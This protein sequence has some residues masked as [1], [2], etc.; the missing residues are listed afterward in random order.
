MPKC[1]RCPVDVPCIGERPAYAWACRIANASDAENR[2][3]VEESARQRG[4]GPPGRPTGP[5]A[6]GPHVEST[7]QGAVAEFLA[8]QDCVHRR[9]EPACGC[10]A[11]SRC[12]K[13]SKDVGV[14]ECI[15]CHRSGDSGVPV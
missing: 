5:V 8:I 13:Y 10:A 9:P 3:V 12:E 14:D 4:H 6:A 7:S 15:A 1:A 11:K 2:W